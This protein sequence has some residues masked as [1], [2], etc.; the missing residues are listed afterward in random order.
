MSK[1]GMLKTGDHD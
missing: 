1:N